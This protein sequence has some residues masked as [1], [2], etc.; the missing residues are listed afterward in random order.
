MASSPPP[1]PD[2]GF[3]LGTRVSQMDHGG[4]ANFLGLRFSPTAL[5]APSAINA[6]NPDDVCLGSPGPNVDNYAETLK[7]YVIW[8][9]GRWRNWSARFV[10]S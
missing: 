1:S 3:E 6:L 10:G 2:P 9:A 5:E 7:E 4:G 8:R